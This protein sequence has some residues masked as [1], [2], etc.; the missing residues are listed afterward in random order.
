[1]RQEKEHLPA[2]NRARAA[3]SSFE[4]IVRC[5]KKSTKKFLRKRLTSILYCGILLMLP[6]DE[7]ATRSLTN[8]QRKEEI[9]KARSTTV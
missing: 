9:T 1:M 2:Q 7:V 4:S 6:L 8:E 3:K 5:L